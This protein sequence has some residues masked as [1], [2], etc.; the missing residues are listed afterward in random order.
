M[1]VDTLLGDLKVPLLLL[2]GE[3][4]PWIVKATGDRVQAT[5]AALGVDVRRVS[6]NAGHCSQD[7]APEE[8]N[9]GLLSFVK[10]LGA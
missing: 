6:V 1:P 10:E 2:W 4:D 5:A 9:A 7:E 3:L 8:V